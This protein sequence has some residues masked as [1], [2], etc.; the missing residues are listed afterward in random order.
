MKS[1]IALIALVLPLAHPQMAAAQ[2]VPDQPAPVADQS[3]DQA[4]QIEFS[5]DAIDYDFENDVVTAKG[6]VLLNRDGYRLR[7]D[8]VIWN[9]KTGIVEA[10]GNIRSVSP[11]GDTA[12]GDGIV[13]T[14]SLR[15]GIV[16]NLLLVLEDGSRLA[17]RKGERF[18]D[19]SLALDNAAYTACA[20]TTEDGCPKNPSWEIKAVKVRYDPVKKRVTYD[21]A[22]IEIF[23]LPVIPLPGLS[24]PISNENR[25]GLLVPAPRFDSTNGFSVSLPYYFN[26]APNQDATVTAQVFTD[27][28]PLISGTFRQLDDKGAFQMTGYATYS[29]RIPTGAVGP[30]P[31]SERDFRGYFATSGRFILDENWTISQSARITSDRTFLRRYDISDDD[32]LRSTI[33]VERIDDSSYFSLAGWAFQTL[34]AGDPQ[35]QVPIALP[36]VDYRKRISDPVWGGNVQIQLNSLAIG[37]TAGQDTQRAFAS[38]RWDLRRLTSLGQEITLTGFARG[39]VYNSED[40]ALNEAAIYSGETGWQ[41]RAIATAAIDVKWPFIGQA[42]GGTQTLTPRFQVVATPAISN[43]SLPNEDSRSVDLEDT[44]LFALNRFP[45]IDRYEDNVRATYGLEWNLTRPNLRIDAVV[46]QSYRLAN[47]S[48]IVPEGTGLSERFSDIVGRT[49]VRFKDIVKFTHRYRLDKD[50]IAVRRNEIDAT[51]GTKNTY[52]QI[53]YLRLN[54]NIAA[55]VEDLS[56]REEVRVGG[57]YQIDQYWSVFGSAII[58]LTDSRE[59]PTSSADGFEPVRHRIG[60]AYDDGC[61]SLGVTWRYDYEDTGDDQRG[62]TFLFRLALRN[63]GV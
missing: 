36:V 21:G 6:N 29:S 32:S 2:T 11:E 7:S 33:N 42:F 48:N 22:R 12:Y 56:D 53:G 37:R 43:L 57:R 46:G 25:S 39:D 18:A 4:D 54:R 55:G 24:H 14:D 47:N 9:R 52:A 62:S 15:D 59:D 23:G 44:N 41:T 35:N 38:A 19:G 31:D 49:E 58:D 63:L 26:L 34:R 10:K 16:D 40:N 27:V 17:A 28:A 5:A 13:L 1:S 3:S 20:V 50:S 51:I 30:L 45:G 60:V 61:L 8:E